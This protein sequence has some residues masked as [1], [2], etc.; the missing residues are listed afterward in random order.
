MLLAAEDPAE[1]AAGEGEAGKPSSQEAP[2]ASGTR[3]RPEEGNQCD[4]DE[5]ILPVEGNGE[6]REHPAEPGS[7][8]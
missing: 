6:D 1:S 5:I 3:G 2:A 4:Q 8:K 7:R